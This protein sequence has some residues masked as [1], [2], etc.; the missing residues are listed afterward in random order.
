MKLFVIKI[1]KYIQSSILTLIQN[2]QTTITVLNNTTTT[3]TT[4]KKKQPKNF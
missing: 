1:T 4:T 3:A 2:A